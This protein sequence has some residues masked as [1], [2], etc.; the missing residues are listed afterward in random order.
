MSKPQGVPEKDLHD[1]AFP[2]PRPHRRHV[3]PE[4]IFGP[5]YARHAV[6]TAPGDLS[7]EVTVLEYDPD[8]QDHLAA[9]ATQDAMTD[10]SDV[11][12]DAPCPPSSPQVID[13]DACPSPAISGTVEGL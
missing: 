10:L 9:E 8:L 1:I 7:G 11:E 12:D 13:V 4:E 2:P 6:S 5:E 3:E